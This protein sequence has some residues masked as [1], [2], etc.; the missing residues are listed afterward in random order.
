MYNSFS[1]IQE[2]LKAYS[3]ESIMNLSQIESAKTMDISGFFSN[4]EK[5]L[6]GIALPWEIETFVILSC[7]SMQ[8]EKK[9]LARQAFI[10]SINYIRN[11]IGK[12]LLKHKGTEAFLEW[13][14]ITYSQ[15]EF[16]CQKNYMF[17]FYRFNHYFTY[18][19]NELDMNSEFKS[20]FGFPHH[21][22]LLLAQLLWFVFSVKTPCPKLVSGI[23]RKFNKHIVN[24]LSISRE[25]YNE[26]FL[27]TGL[28]VE[29]CAYSLRPS[30][31]YPFISENNHVYLPT[32]HL[33][34]QAVTTSMLYRLTDK[35]NAL[36][37][38][39][40]KIVF[41]DYLEMLS[42][43]SGIYDEIIPEQVYNVDGSK[44]QNRTLDLLTRI[45]D[46]I[47]L[48]DS[49]SFTPKSALRLFSEDAY[50]KDIERLAEAVA[51][52][53]THLTVKFVKQYYYFTY[54]VNNVS[55]NNVYGIVIVQEDPHFFMERI[56][57]K[58]KEQLEKDGIIVNMEF[59]KKHVGLLSIYDYERIVLC[60]NDIVDLLC[61]RE[62]NQYYNFDLNFEDVIKDESY[63]EFRD[64][65]V[66][67]A[68]GIAM[69]LA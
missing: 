69:T 51:Q 46:T 48:F 19:D 57:N 60:K 39:I 50:S 61:K 9:P 3:F 6:A 40:G 1:E 58:A 4:P 29:N 16:E 32:P 45:N 33:L 36:R 21:D 54:D 20:K 42:R 25:D 22:Y 37:E 2:A 68:M 44:V 24:Y 38:K 23:N 18:F 8:N 13:F 62:Y 63:L 17:L 49:K 35:N 66:K 28:S 52:V 31:S 34:F 26:L 59:M 67:E 43:K 65:F 5:G 15:I 10:D 7:M 64:K 56:Y 11:Y 27:K 55:D 12:N 47:I 41:E 53:Y 14:M 30:Y